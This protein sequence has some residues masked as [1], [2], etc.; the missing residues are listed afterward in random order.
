MAALMKVFST[1][2][3]HWKKSTFFAVASSYGIYYLHDRYRANLLRTEFCKEAQLYGK[4][5]ATF[6]TERPRK[7]TV[8]LNPAA[9][10][11]K[12]KKLFDKNA[13]PLLN[14]A[15]I[16]VEIIKTEY[17][18]HAKDKASELETTDAIV[19]AGGDGTVGEVITGL[20]R[21]DDEKTLSSK[22]PLAVIPIGTSNTLAK[23]LYTDAESEVR[24]MCNAA[25]SVIRGLTK[26]VDV[27]AI[28][29]EEGR[30]VFAV[31]GLDWG[32]FRDAN[33]KMPKYWYFGP[34]KKKLTYIF[35]ALGRGWP[36][37][38]TAH[39]S[40]RQP[41]PDPEPEI[42]ETPSILWR[43]FS[44]IWI[45]KAQLEEEAARKAQE[46]KEKEEAI[47]WYDLDVS[48]QE[49]LIKTDNIQ[50]TNKDLSSLNL[51]TKPND[52]TRKNFIKEGWNRTSKKKDDTQTILPTESLEF[53]EMK[54]QPV[55]AEGQ[56]S[57]FDLD[58]EKFEAM[59]IH[60]KLLRKK[61]YFYT[62]Q[63]MTSKET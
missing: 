41:M 21:R 57:W 6:A 12:A 11:G 40:Y 29:D 24:W 10:K 36:S 44:W 34:L 48:T 19:V 51:I 4:Q 52:I 55:K 59:P 39:I 50:D 35:H 14:L 23:M 47:P 43:W 53:G 15:G 22:W 46:E 33:E 17:E 42:V 38:V 18:G 7:V 5:L 31:C 3:N 28:K 26:P 13:A 9:K 25:M 37:S 2:R 63:P 27:M 20:L 62:N 56:E 1:L 60:I 30:E 8:F 61:L 58:N 45:S 54:L 16:E 49:L 32:A